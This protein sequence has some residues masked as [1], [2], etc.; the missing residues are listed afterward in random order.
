MTEP[1]A[2]CKAR[3]NGADAAQVSAGLETP[4]KPGPNLVVMATP[5]LVAA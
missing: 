1:I 5:F 2:D 4:S 3:T